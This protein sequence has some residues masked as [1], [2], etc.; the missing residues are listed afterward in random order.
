MDINII[1]T[2]G[3][4]IVRAV[5][6]GVTRT[7]TN[8]AP[9][10]TNAL[11][12]T[13]AIEHFERVATLF[14]KPNV[15]DPIMQGYIKKI[16][17]IPVEGG[18][19][20]EELP[21]LNLV[22]ESMFGMLKKTKGKSPLYKRIVF[23]NARPDGIIRK[24]GVAFV[25]WETGSLHVNRDYL[26][27]IDS[28]IKDNLKSFMD[29]GWITKDRNGKYRIVDHLRNSK[30]EVFERR[31]NEYSPNWSLRDKF[32][33]HRVSMN[34]YANLTYQAYG[35]PILTIEKIMNS[36]NNQQ[37]LKKLGLFKTRDEVIKMSKTE[38]VAYL[39]QIGKHCPPPV[40]SCLVTYPEFL[41]NHEGIHRFHNDCI[42]AKMLQELQ[43]K[44]KIQEWKT[45][46]KIQTT[47]AKVS[48]YAGTLP[49]EYVA[50]VGGGLAG[51]Q[52]FDNDVMSLYELLKGPKI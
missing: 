13:P 15:L 43:S 22:H 48:G 8:T 46:E 9:V 20:R 33:F 37:I 34:Y 47:A 51:G 49:V 19:T 36:G 1:K 7:T 41:F 16:N 42:S 45:N 14:S 40:N 21:I 26:E 24:D 50:E 39:M 3:T 28:N 2:V 27:N 17:A 12:R 31:L 5:E 11:E 30:S 18:V 29:L 23:E 44:A 38:Q 10:I 6:S 35:H 25:D 32:L 4:K 52:T